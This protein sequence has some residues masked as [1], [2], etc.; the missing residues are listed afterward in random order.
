[1]DVDPPVDRFEFWVRFSC[2]AVFGSLLGFA[3]WLNLL[4]PVIL[5]W[6]V[7]PLAAVVFGLAAAWWGDRFWHFILGLFRWW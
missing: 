2:G 6:A 3:L 4:T 5:E 1:M 7:I